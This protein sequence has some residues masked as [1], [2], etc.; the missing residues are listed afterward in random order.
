MN[1]WLMTDD[2]MTYSQK[3]RDPRWQKKRLLI[4]ERDKWTCQSCR[5][6]TKTLQV[7]HLVYAR[8][9]PWDYADSCYQTL[10]DECHE[11]RQELTDKSSNALKLVLRDIPTDQ[12]TRVANQ[13]IQYASGAEVLPITRTWPLNADGDEKFFGYVVGI[14]VQELKD[15][16]NQYYADFEYGRSRDR[17][18]IPKNEDLIMELVE[19]LQSNLTGIYGDGIYGKVWI[20]RVSESQYNVS[21]P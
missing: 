5:S 19:V 10:C 1:W 3:L 16:S 12:L 8:R 14:G 6:T 15:G 17:F 18:Q 2:D 13:L 11:I 9:D 20:K 4:L 7:H 21:L